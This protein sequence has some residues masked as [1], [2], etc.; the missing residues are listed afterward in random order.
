MQVK[1]RIRRIGSAKVRILHC[2]MLNKGIDLG[3]ICAISDK[4]QPKF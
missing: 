3:L 4:R 1:P 2:A